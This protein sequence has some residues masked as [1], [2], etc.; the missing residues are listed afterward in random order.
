MS[1]ATS[2]SGIEALLHVA[3]LV[4]VPKAAQAQ[5]VLVEWRED[6]AV[7]QAA[8]HRFGGQL[9]GLEG[10]LARMRVRLAQHRRLAGQGVLHQQARAAGFEAQ[11]VQAFQPQRV[12]RGAVAGDA[13][14]AL[15]HQRIGDQQQLGRLEI[16][17][18]AQQLDRHL[19]ADA[20]RVAGQ[21][22]DSGLGRHPWFSPYSARMPVSFTSLP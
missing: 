6:D 18:A 22:R 7:D 3:Q 12:E 13:L 2:F 15:Q 1:A 5:R 9:H 8:A 14:A 21:Q 17:H 4:L 11:G 10:G 20:A 16:G 19:G